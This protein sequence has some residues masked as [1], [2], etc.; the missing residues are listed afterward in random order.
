MC[1]RL[2]REGINIYPTV[3]DNQFTIT[4]DNDKQYRILMYDLRGVEYLNTTIKD[5][6]NLIQN[7]NLNKG[8]YIIKIIGENGFVETEKIIKM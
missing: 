4:K 3:V 6:T 2:H 1:N 8:M 5:Y 7:L